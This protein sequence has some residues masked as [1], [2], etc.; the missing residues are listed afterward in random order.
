METI[1]P[2][3]RLV[4]TLFLVFV[5]ISHISSIGMSLY[6]VG[7]GY[8]DIV[9]HY[10]GNEEANAEEGGMEGEMAF[11]KEWI[12]L[13]EVTHFHA[14]IEG[15]LLLVLAHLFVAVPWQT[16]LKRWIIVLA[17]GGTLLDLFSPWLIRF[18]A[19]AFA[20]GQITAWIL[21]HLLV[22]KFKK[23]VL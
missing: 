22:P 17:F 10:R 9:K 15:I 16:V 21:M 23:I 18:V 19:E 5:V 7:P 14:A 13:L 6:R 2:E 20:Y 1:S 8:D 4:Y 12:E 3:I 11:P